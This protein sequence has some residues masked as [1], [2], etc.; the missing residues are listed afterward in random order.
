MILP[1]VKYPDS[2]LKRR[3]EPISSFDGYLHKLAESMVET[4]YAA[5][6]VGLAAPQVGELVRLIVV[7]PKAGEE[8][9]QP[10]ILVNPEVLWEEGKQRGEEGCL[11]IPGLTSVVERPFHIRVKAQTLE[12][13]PLEVEGTEL[14]ARILH[15]EIDH[16]DGT[17]FIDRLSPLQREVLKRKIR[18]LMRSG[19]W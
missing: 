2:I 1:I 11:S 10:L 4:M 13:E 19:E 7:D 8:S 17:L 5:P 14:L 16:L 15:H 3:C 18:K 12:G 9:A 6:G